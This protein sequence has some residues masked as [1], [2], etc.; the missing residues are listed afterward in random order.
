MSDIDSSSSS[1]KWDFYLNNN[2][3]VDKD[4]DQ[5]SDDTLSNLC[6]LSLSLDS[7]QSASGKSS[8]AK[9]K[10]IRNVETVKKCS[11]ENEFCLFL[12]TIDL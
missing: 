11:V 1:E 10:K 5:L 4:K 8:S 6:L 2:D 12:K 9:S 3:K 7:P